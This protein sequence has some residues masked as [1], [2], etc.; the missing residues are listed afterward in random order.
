MDR[1][2]ANHVKGAKAKDDLSYW[3]G[4]VARFFSNHGVLRH[5]VLINDGDESTDKQYEIAFPAIARYFHT[6]FSSGVRSM[7]LIMDKGLTDRPMPGEGHCI[8]N[9]RAS[10]VYWFEAGSHVRHSFVGKK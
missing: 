10:L 4:F 1:C 3:N 8:E 2:E 6:H 9:Q 7:Q 5:S